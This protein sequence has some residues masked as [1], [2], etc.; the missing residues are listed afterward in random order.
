MERKMEREMMRK[1][2]REIKRKCVTGGL[3]EKEGERR[4]REGVC[5]L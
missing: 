1:M 2:V 5:E 3:C 4:E